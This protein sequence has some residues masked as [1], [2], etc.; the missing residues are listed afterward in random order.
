MIFLIG[1]INTQ[2]ALRKAGGKKIWIKIP[3]TNATFC[4]FI[5][6]VRSFLLLVELYSIIMAGC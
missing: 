5:M 1:A 4:C 6:P 3:V 2:I